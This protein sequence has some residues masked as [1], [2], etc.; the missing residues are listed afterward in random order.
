MNWLF[1]CVA[2]AAALLALFLLLLCVRGMRQRW[3]SAPIFKIYRRLLPSMSQTERD[4]LEAGTVWWEGDLFVGNPDW[5]KLLAYPRPRL[6]PAEQNGSQVGYR[7]VYGQYQ[8]RAV[9][10]IEQSYVPLGM[11]D[12]VRQY[13]NELDPNKSGS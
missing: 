5:E 1:L 2:V 4:A 3:L 6:S 13:F 10:N 7:D 12:L 9:Q 8:D 11:K